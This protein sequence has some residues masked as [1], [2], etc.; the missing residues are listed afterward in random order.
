MRKFIVST[1]LAGSLALA[2]CAGTTI[3]TLDP[4][5]VSQVQTTAAQICGFLPTVTT[6]ANVIAALVGAGNTVSTITSAAQGICNAVTT[7]SARRGGV[8]PSFMG[9]AIQGKFIR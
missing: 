1:F 2:G 9:V 7:K 6:V 4:N 8:A 5:V 3:P